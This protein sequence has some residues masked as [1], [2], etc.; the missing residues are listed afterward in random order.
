MTCR[1]R[2]ITATPHNS[3]LCKSSDCYQQTSRSTAIAEGLHDVPVNCCTAIWKI[4]FK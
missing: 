1:S 4:T 3:D 2:E